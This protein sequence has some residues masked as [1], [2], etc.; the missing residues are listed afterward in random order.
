MIRNR[1]FWIIPLA[2]AAAAGF[3]IGSGCRKSEKADESQIIAKVGAKVFTMADLDRL[4]EDQ[5]RVKMPVYLSK[6]DLM[7]E[8]ISSEVV[9]QYALK[10]KV[11]QEKE[12]AWRLYNTNK[13]IV[14]RR[15]WELNVYDKYPE[16]SEAD[17]LKWYEENKDKEYRTKKTAVWVR[18]ILLNSPEKANEVLARLKAG[19]D[20]AKI[21]AKDS[22]TP[23]KLESGSQGYRSLDN[24][25]PEYRD[26]VAKL[27]PG[28]Y[29]G[30]FKMATFY[31][32]V[33]LE[34]RVEPGGYLKPAGIGMARLREKAKVEKWRAEINRTGKE[35]EANAKIERHPERVR[36]TAV[37]M[38]PEKTKGITAGTGGKASK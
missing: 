17:A 29:A 10:K 25:S 11:D 19:E 8:W 37:E 5:R 20:F 24:L 2:A 16:M 28:E 7:E 34:D 38:V 33:K 18:R 12:C 14:I 15:F 26:A 35:L 27:K 23:E 3:V 21:A 30:P 1:Y 22:V 13:G 32:I 9:Y 6:K 36:E 31:V 4:D